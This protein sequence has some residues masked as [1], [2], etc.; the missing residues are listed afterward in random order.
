MTIF[1]LY[2]VAICLYIKG[3]HMLS[4]IPAEYVTY[5]TQFRIGKEPPVGTC[6]QH[7]T[8]QGHPDK[9]TGQRTSDYLQ[10]HGHFCWNGR[11]HLRYGNCR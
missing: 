8:G 2:I 3:K 1:C 7:N 9:G 5:I 4:P 10:I 6:E 11:Y